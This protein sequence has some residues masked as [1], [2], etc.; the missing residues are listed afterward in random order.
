MQTTA[1]YVGL[2]LIAAGAWLRLKSRGETPK[3]RRFPRWGVVLLAA[4][5]LFFAAS[6][7]RGPI[8]RWTIDNNDIRI[9]NYKGQ[10]VMKWSDL[11]EV[12][13]DSHFTALE[14]ATLVLQS[15]DGRTIWLP[16]DWL[17]RRHREQLIGLLNRYASEA[18]K[19]VTGNQDYINALKG[20]P[21]ELEGESKGK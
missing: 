8:T 18:M 5:G 3:P 20:V 12:R 7:L 19:P 17:L 11:K 1:R 15:R 14:N 9:E 4:G 6:F 2:G 16:L 10:A 13:L 21:Q